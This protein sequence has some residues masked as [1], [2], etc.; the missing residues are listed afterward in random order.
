MTEFKGITG[1]GRYRTAIGSQVTVLENDGTNVWPWVCDDGIDR[2]SIGEDGMKGKYDITA[3]PLSEEP[4]L[5]GLTGFVALEP[6]AVAS[7]GCYSANDLRVVNHWSVVID[8]SSIRK[9]Q[10]V[11]PE[12]VREVRK[13]WMAIRINKRGEEA[14]DAYRD[15]PSK[16]AFTEPVAIFETEIT[17]SP[18]EGL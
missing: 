5:A 18:G 17:F 6:G 14:I 12:P 16:S 11:K 10:L 2:N 13:V 7:N 4:E 3:G 8:L 15:K 9:D 1:P